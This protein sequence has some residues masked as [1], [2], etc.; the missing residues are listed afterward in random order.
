MGS[1]EEV[2]VFIYV[3]IEIYSTIAT[4]SCDR[5]ANKAALFHDG[6]DE[7]LKL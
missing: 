2:V 7:V 1:R 3:R 6:L 4:S 5:D